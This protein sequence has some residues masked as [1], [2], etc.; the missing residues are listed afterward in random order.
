MEAIER[1]EHDDDAVCSVDYRRRRC[2]VNPETAAFLRGVIVGFGAAAVASV[3]FNLFQEQRARRRHAMTTD[4]RM[5]TYDESGG[6]MGDLSNLVDEGTSAFRDAVRTL[7]RTF[8][9][10]VRAIETVQDIID[11]IRE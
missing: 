3:C 1:T 9:S 2:G 10:G 4:S 7:D 6:V 8:E 5:R 11:K